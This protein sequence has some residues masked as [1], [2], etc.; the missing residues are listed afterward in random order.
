[1][2]MFKKIIAVVL[3]AILAFSCVAVAGAAGTPTIKVMSASAAPGETVTLDVQMQNNPGI[4]TFSLGF[5]YDTSRLKLKDVKVE[6]ALGGQYSYGT[7]VV[8]LNDANSTYNGKILTLTFDVLDNAKDGDAS[9]AV[10]YSAGDISDYDENDVNFSLVSGKVTVKKAEAA[11]GLISVSSVSANVGTDFSV[12][13]SIDKNPGINTFSLGFEYDNSVLSLENVEISENLG[14][15]FAYGKK[16][17]WFGDADT[18]YTGKILTLKFKVLDS[19]AEGD[20]TV[21]VVY[22]PGDISNY[23]EEDVDFDTSPGVVTVKKEVSL[24]GISVK[25]NPSKLSYFVNEHLDTTGLSLNAVYS[26]GKTEVVTGGYTCTPT[27]LTVAGT[28]KITVSYQ[29]RTTSFNVNVSEVTSRTP[30]IKVEN[31]TAK[32]G[33]EV[34]VNVYVTNNPGFSFLKIRLYYDKTSLAFVSAENGEV[35]TDSMEIGNRTSALLEAVLWS[36][37]TD[38]TADGKLVTL[39]FKVLDNTAEGDYSVST[40]VVEAY[41]YDEDEVNFM[42]VDGVITVRNIVYGDVNGDGKVNGRDAVKLSKYLAA[43]DES[44]GESSVT[45]SPGADVNGDG[46][47]NGRDLVKL[48]KYLANYNE[49]TGESTI[50]LGPSK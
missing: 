29:G 34:L 45:V 26:N 43:Y 14:G 35:S 44:T 15:Q 33:D 37:A 10:T 49:S 17:V 47:I 9:V 22:S 27:T 19:A 40:K 39:K 48:R 5:K 21:K 1:M 32:A 12:D 42:A 41:N 2:K 25:T 13:V 6:S 20:T 11:K 36:S 50:V 24:V 38:A 28:Q 18:S 30:S 3:A 31:T 8:W 4:N 7:R 16:A 46:K 23:D